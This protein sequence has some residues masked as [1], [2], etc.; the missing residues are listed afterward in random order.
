MSIDIAYL[1]IPAPPNILA[2]GICSW[3][4]SWDN[5]I[6]CLSLAYW[7]QIYTGLLAPAQ[8]ATLEARVLYEPQFTGSS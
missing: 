6:R 8:C 1:C 4:L 2:F 3:S 5:L 7:S